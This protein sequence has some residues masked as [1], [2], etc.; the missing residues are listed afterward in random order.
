MRELTSGCHEGY[1][2][3]GQELEPTLARLP[4]DDQTFSK[5]EH[6]VDQILLKEIHHVLSHVDEAE[7]IL[8]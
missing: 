4:R 2:A 1:E 8:T 5:A 6:G 3:I 7:K